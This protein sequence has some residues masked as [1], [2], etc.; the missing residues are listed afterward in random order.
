MHR[1]P[2]FPELSG[3][4]VIILAL[5]LAAVSALV[6][7]SASAQVS[8]NGVQTTLFSGYNQPTGVAVDSSGN[9]YIAVFGN[10]Q[11]LKETRQPNGT[12]VESTV[13]GNPG[14][15]VGVAVDA[16]GNVYVAPAY[17]NL[18]KE[19]PQGG[20][21]YVQSTVATAN[22]PQAV[23]VDASGN[24][25]F[26]DTNNNQALEETPA[27]VPLGSS[28]TQTTIATGLNSPAGIAV[29]AA[30]N[31]YIADTGNNQILK[32]TQTSG[33]FNSPIAILTGLNAPRGISA[34]T[35]GDLYIA[36][37]G[38]NRVLVET[39]VSGSYVQS[40]I[41][42]G[43]NNPTDATVDQ[44]GNEFIAD[45]G[46]IRIVEVTPADFASQ[47]V[48]SPSTALALNFTVQSGTTIGSIGVLTTGLANKDFAD[49]GGSNCTAQTYSILTY[50]FVNVALTPHAPGTR[51]GAVAIFDNLGN[52]LA[53]VPLYGIGTGPQNVFYPSTT[54]TFNL[55]VGDSPHMIAVDGNSNLYVPDLA[56]N[57]LIKITNTGVQ[58]V[59][60]SAF[61]TPVSVAIDG[62]GNLFVVNYPAPG[63][64]PSITE[65]SPNGASSTFAINGAQNVFGIALDAP[66]NIYLADTN[67]NSIYKIAPNGTQS[68]FAAGVNT[69]LGLA[70]DSAGNIYVSD[71]DDGNIYKFTPQGVQTTV[72]TGLNQPAGLAVDA[73]GDIFYTTI[74]TPT[75]GVIPP[76]GTPFTL[77]TYASGNP[78]G[79][80]VDSSGNLYYS[81]ETGAF[82]SRL[83]RSIAPTLTF[84]TTADGDT[85][86]DS[87]VAAAIQNVGNGSL[88]FASIEYPTDYK[89]DPAGAETDCS[90]SQPLAISA[91]C[92]FYVDFAPVSIDG[93]SNPVSRVESI[94]V[95]TN[96]LNVP[97]LEH[98]VLSGSETE[99]H[100]TIALGASSLTPLVGSGFSITATVSGASG[101]PAGTVTFYS[102][103]VLLSSPALS[104]GQATIT[105]GLSA[106]KHTITATYSGS[107]TYAGSS[108]TPLVLTVGKN[109][110]TIELGTSS[111]PSPH[112]TS[113]TFTATLTGPV[114][115]LPSGTVK[116]YS[117]GAYIGSGTVSSGVATFA[118]SSLPV[119]THTITA[120]YQGDAN[121]NSLTS[122][123]LKQTITTPTPQP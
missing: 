46:N 70:L 86:T 44:N 120:T 116:F 14:F 30:G 33:V 102:G 26:T 78:L 89:E 3:F 18:L 10:N 38:N 22:A 92:T 24:V 119:G 5:A 85:S 113:I 121:Y 19:T 95:S 104:A 71:V 39:L 62:A 82:V 97:N 100:S 34:D 27:G 51:R 118:T 98:I 7:S 94:R 75:V 56:N 105:P 111:T 61:T 1:N 25:Y 91:V 68:V 103:G 50:C 15:P 54:T 115:H 81:D 9:V 20:G 52:T 67:T 55:P 45:D 80:A 17:G 114:G 93:A 2:T 41:G 63:P 84:A 57:Q 64:G 96:S 69:P 106:A 76:T 28:Y 87:P 4:R 112:G 23:A 6:V 8:F 66:G 123:G 77:V 107:G 110:T 65:I 13:D 37:S 72:A 40:I 48:A 109:T 53:S 16:S 122:T 60:G 49:A 21:T 12:F 101:T 90:T 58:S 47:P 42:A 74:G 29:D 36:E 32:V 35:S 88:N 117:G 31:V 11:L 59:V 83:N 43:L 73:A 99:A 108:T 79:V